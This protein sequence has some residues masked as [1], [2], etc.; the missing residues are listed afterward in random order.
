MSLHY[1]IM[2]FILQTS[3]MWSSCSDVLVEMQITLLLTVDEEI[4][5]AYRIRQG[6]GILLKDSYR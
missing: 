3:R 4:Q 5:Y 1:L 6:L 2:Y